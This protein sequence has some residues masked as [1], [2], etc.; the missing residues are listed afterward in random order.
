MLVSFQHNIHVQINIT[1]DNGLLKNS[2]HPHTHTS[3]SLAIVHTL[4]VSL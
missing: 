4:Y 3:S 2:T 1:A